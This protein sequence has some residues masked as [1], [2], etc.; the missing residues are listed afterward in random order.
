MTL[1]MSPRRFRRT[2]PLSIAL[3][4]N[5]SINLCHFGRKTGKSKVKRDKIK[6]EKGEKLAWVYSRK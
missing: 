5:F 1:L 6:G 2:V 4:Q 3:G